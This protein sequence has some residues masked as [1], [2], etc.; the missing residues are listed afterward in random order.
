MK[1]TPRIG[2]TRRDVRVHSFWKTEK[3]LPAGIVLSG[4]QI[5]EGNRNWRIFC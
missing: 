3:D 4:D 2:I 1:P 5:V